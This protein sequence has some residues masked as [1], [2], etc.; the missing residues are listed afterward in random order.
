MS[1]L[2]F[3]SEIDKSFILY[4][5][6]FEYKIS[7]KLI[8]RIPSVKI[9]PLEIDL[10]KASDERILNFAAESSPFKSEVGFDS[11]K[12]NFLALSRIS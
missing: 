8:F 5:K 1:L 2:F 3:I 10:L 11:A 9:F 12:P 6:V 4:P 7:F